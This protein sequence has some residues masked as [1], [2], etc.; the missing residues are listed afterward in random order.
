M[1][2]IALLL[3][4]TLTTMAIV[5]L[6]PIVPQLMAEFSHV[7]HHEYLVPMVLTLPALCVAILCPF[8]GILGD[9]FGRRKLLLA[10]FIIYALVG[11]A[12]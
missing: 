11:V 4:I 2:G 3:P 8:A 6:A 9:Y 7:P 5:L 12:P 10:S 1:T